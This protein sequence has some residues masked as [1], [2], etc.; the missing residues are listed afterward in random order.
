M[1][2]KIQNMSGLFAAVGN[3][4]FVVFLTAFIGT[5]FAFSHPMADF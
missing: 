4:E 3:Q 5:D 2:S 1:K